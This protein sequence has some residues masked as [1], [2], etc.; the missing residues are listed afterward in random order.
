[1]AQKK[2]Q[3]LSEREKQGK[4]APEPVM[5][6]TPHGNKEID[7]APNETAPIKPANTDNSIRIFSEAKAEAKAEVIPD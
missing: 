6:L 5:Q 2:K 4:K 7:K 3:G 1:M